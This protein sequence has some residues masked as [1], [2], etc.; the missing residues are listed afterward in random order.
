MFSTP[1]KIVS[2][3]GDQRAKNRRRS[4]SLP[5]APVE[6]AQSHFFAPYNR[7]AKASNADD[8]FISRPDLL[9]RDL[10]KSSPPP[11]WLLHLHPN[12]WVY[13]THPVFGLVTNADIRQ[14]SVYGRL[15]PIFQSAYLNW[16]PRPA[17]TEILI[18]D[19]MNELYVNHSLKLASFASWNDLNAEFAES[20]SWRLHKIYEKN[21]WKCFKDHPSHHPLPEGAEELATGT[22]NSSLVGNYVYQNNSVDPFSADE[23]EKLR[24]LLSLLRSED[25]IPK[26][27]LISHILE[28][29]ATQASE[30]NYTYFSTARGG[31]TRKSPAPRSQAD[32][33][34]E[35]FSDKLIAICMTY[36]LFG[37]PFNYVRHIGRV[38]RAPP[39]SGSY[40][41]ELKKKQWQEY[42]QKLVKEWTDF[43]LV[44]TVLLSATVSFLAVPGIDDVTRVTT[45]ISV[46]CALGSIIVGLYLVWKHQTRGADMGGWSYN[47]NLENRYGVHEIATLL[48]LPLVFLIWA[49]LTFMI[50]VVCFSFRGFGQTI[51]GTQVW[52]ETSTAWIVLV[53]AVV[54]VTTSGLVLYSFWDL[55]QNPFRRSSFIRTM[56]RQMGEGARWIGSGM[57]RIARMISHR[58]RMQ[59]PNQEQMSGA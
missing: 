54:I 31:F 25:S 10:P 34:A 27:V 4:L 51:D 11:G 14:P 36:L 33:V 12:G 23:S 47:L 44:A 39:G 22:V 52:F 56:I 58:D 6:M 38:L 32:P 8:L 49:I 48:S 40:A 1:S 29:I 42:V 15:N 17:S 59:V 7:E 43:N 26:T 2:T 28:L 55:W 35:R 20:Q 19:D 16:Q 41:Y 21:Y 18:D 45:L 3:M 24:K 53:V 13:F 50:S 57:R 46:L 9:P 30:T 37:V 5:S